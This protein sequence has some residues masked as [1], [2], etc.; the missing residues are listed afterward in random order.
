MTYNVFGGTL[1]LAQSNP[2]GGG[3][4]QVLAT[5]RYRTWYTPVQHT[6]T[7]VSGILMR[8]SRYARTSLSTQLKTDAPCSLETTDRHR[9]RMQ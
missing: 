4:L 6:C 1:N 8:S 3:L 9:I 7:H 2:G 5:S